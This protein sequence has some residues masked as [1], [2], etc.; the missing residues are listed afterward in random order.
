MS[1]DILKDREKIYRIMDKTINFSGGME[2]YINIHKITDPI[3]DAEQMKQALEFYKKTISWNID[4]LDL[5]ASILLK[6]PIEIISYIVFDNNIE[7][8]DD[9]FSSF[10][11]IHQISYH[12]CQRKSHQYIETKKFSEKYVKKINNFTDHQISLMLERPGFITAFAIENDKFSPNKDQT[13]QILNNSH[14]TWTSNVYT[15]IKSCFRDNYCIKRYEKDVMFYNKLFKNNNL[16]VE[17]LNIAIEFRNFNMAIYLLE[18][19]VIPNNKTLSLFLETKHGWMCYDAK[20]RIN[21]IDKLIS[22]NMM[23]YT[24]ELL[25]HAANTY[26]TELISTILNSK[27]IINPDYDKCIKGY[28]LQKHE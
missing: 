11:K 20:Q 9:T 13:M 16:H 8:D 6:F 5:H 2:K 14:Y 19:N 21:L 1:D 24:D 27:K 22:S 25:I 3:L 15:S 26:N 7:F 10:Y 18:N 28:F 23:E 17:Y 4:S 12:C